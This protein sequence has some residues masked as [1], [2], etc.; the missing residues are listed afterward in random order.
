M[1]FN[2]EVGE[3]H[4][5]IEEV[6]GDR[7]VGE[8]YWADE[9]VGGNVEVGEEHGAAEDGGEGYIGVAELEVGDE[10]VGDVGGVADLVNTGNRHV[11]AP[12]LKR[13]KC[14]PSQRNTKLR[15]RW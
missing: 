12:N 10:Q 4:G 13:T 15:L 1:L 6:G 8:G 11:V 2:A 3:R 14:G 7:E 9:E 5:T